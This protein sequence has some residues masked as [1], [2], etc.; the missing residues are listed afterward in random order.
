[1]TVD[2]VRAFAPQVLQ[3]CHIELLAHGN[4]HH[5]DALSFTKLVEST[6]RLYRLPLT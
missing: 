1:M 5:E 4:L 6:L 2:D 3:Q